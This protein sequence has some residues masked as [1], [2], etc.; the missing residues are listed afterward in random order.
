MEIRTY[1][2]I[3]GTLKS[4]TIN[5]GYFPTPHIGFINS[6]HIKPSTNAV[7]RYDNN[8]ELKKALLAAQDWYPVRFLLFIYICIFIFMFQRCI[9]IIKF[10]FYRFISF[11]MKLICILNYYYPILFFFYFFCRIFFFL[12]T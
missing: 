10:I 1:Q 7:I 12:F 8:Y 3:W 5:R 4:S 9:F 2:K 6:S 11:R